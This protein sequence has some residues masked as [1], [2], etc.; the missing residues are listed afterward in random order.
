MQQHD[1]RMRSRR[2][3]YSLSKRP[4]IDFDNSLLRVHALDRF[5]SVLVHPPDN[6][7]Q[8]PQSKPDKEQGSKPEKHAGQ[9]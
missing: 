8:N 1:D 4:T 3:G 2:S 5:E 7:V 6:Q 9:A